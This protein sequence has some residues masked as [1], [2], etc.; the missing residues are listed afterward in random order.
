MVIQRI[1]DTFTKELQ[2]VTTEHKRILTLSNYHTIMLR[3]NGQTQEVINHI[4][5]FVFFVGYPRSGHSIV[6]SL[7]DAYPHMHGYI[8]AV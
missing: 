4:E 5:K 7:M 2:T 1:M 8:H 3:I 6:G